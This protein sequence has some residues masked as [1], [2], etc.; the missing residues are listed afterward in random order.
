VLILND[1]F[2][3]VDLATRIQELPTTTV[4]TVTRIIFRIVEL[5]YTPQQ[6]QISGM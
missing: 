5:R 1:G 6:I 2:Q 3:L 4:T